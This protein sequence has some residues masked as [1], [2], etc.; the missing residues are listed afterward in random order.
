[1]DVEPGPFATD[2]ACARVL[3]AARSLDDLAGRQRRSTTSQSTA[4]WGDPA[5]VL[6]CGVEP[7]GPTTQPCLDAGGVDWVVDGTRFTTY[8]R[9]P[10]V[11]VLLPRGVQPIEV[12][13]QLGALVTALPQSRECL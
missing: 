12:L 5:V 8:G 13:G 1:V 3:V 4:A 11:E 9:E 10:A 7:P 6:R 2:P